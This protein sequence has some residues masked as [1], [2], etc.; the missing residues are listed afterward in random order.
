MTARTFTL[1]AAAMLIGLLEIG[2]QQPTSQAHGAT[3]EQEI[4]QS[5]TSNL[6]ESY[7]PLTFSDIFTTRPLPALEEQVTPAPTPITEEQIRHEFEQA[8][9]LIERGR[10]REAK[11]ALNQFVERYP[12][13]SYSAQALYQIALLETQVEQAIQVLQRLARSYPDSSWAHIGFYR[14]GELY[15]FLEQY[16][17]ARDAFEQYLVHQPNGQ[18]SDKAHQ[19]IVI[20]LMRMGNYVEALRQLAM[21]QKNFPEFEHDPEIIDLVSECY[22]QLGYIEKAYE[23]LQ[24][25]VTKFPNY[26]FLPKIYLNLGLCQEELN[27]WDEAENTY[28]ELTRL[29]PDSPEALLARVRIADLTMPLLG[30]S[31]APT[32]TTLPS[33]T[34]PTSPVQ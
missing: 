7:L 24:T 26:T 25:I 2:G 20:C 9:D 19:R 33:M 8:L 22:A 14:L 3:Q 15:F 34:P 29:F 6:P 5:D 10:A 21:L 4:L 28:A 16:K 13:S 17:Q 32:S 18:F 23:Y 27:R 11:S 12:E 30:Q 31:G 1:V